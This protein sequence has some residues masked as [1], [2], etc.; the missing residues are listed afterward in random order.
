MCVRQEIVHPFAKQDSAVVIQQNK[1][2]K[3]TAAKGKALA[4]KIAPSAAVISLT[5]LAVV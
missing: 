2:A 3:A 5:G 4:P 1:V